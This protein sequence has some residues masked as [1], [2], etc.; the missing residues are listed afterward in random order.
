MYI[1]LVF[2]I[3]CSFHTY[4]SSVCSFSSQYL[5]FRKSPRSYVLLLTPFTSVIYPS[6]TS[7]GRQFLLRIWPIQLA[8]LLRILFSSVLFSLMTSRTFSLVTLSDNFIFSILLQHNISKLSKYSRSNFLNVQISEPY[9][10][11]HQTYP[12]TNFFLNS[13]FILLF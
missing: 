6:M 12:L 1:S 7:W 9:N 2:L 4:R 10:S 3:N 11:M 8:F 13:M 5:L